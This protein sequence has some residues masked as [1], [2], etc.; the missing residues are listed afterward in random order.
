M[1]THWWNI[2]RALTFGGRPSSQLLIVHNYNYKYKY[3]YN[4]NYSRS[5]QDNNEME[6]MDWRDCTYCSKT[7]DICIGMYQVPIRKAIV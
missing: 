4:Y 5:N 3:D 6:K 7:Q 1:A 2:E